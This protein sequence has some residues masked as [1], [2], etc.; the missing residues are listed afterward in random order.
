MMLEEAGYNPFVEGADVDAK[1]EQ[2]DNN[3]SNNNRGSFS[4]IESD[5]SYVDKGRR[6]S[7]A[8]N[9]PVTTVAQPASTSS[10]RTST[11]NSPSLR[12]TLP[13]PASPIQEEE[14]VSTKDL[15]NPFVNETVS[16]NDEPAGAPTSPTM[17]ALPP[18][19]PLKGS[20]ERQSS[21]RLPSSPLA[22][23]SP[24]K[25]E[26]RNSSLLH[27]Q[28]SSVVTVEKAEWVPDTDL[29][30]MVNFNICF[31]FFLLTFK[32]SWVFF[33]FLHLFSFRFLHFPFLKL[34]L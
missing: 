19:S 33:F 28:R 31:S 25:N 21:P 16:L 29:L 5:F 10:P 2:P 20:S 23:S 9:S 3:N 15:A 32:N 34:I 30:F 8:E 6:L 27:Q 13:S 24:S 1:A 22:S 17:A 12:L 7:F 14:E 11:R 4:F 26:L 18:G